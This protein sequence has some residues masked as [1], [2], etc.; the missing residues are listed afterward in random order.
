MAEA[1]PQPAAPQVDSIAAA[2]LAGSLATARGLDSIAAAQLL[3][4][5]ITARL[6]EL[7]VPVVVRDTIGVRFFHE[8]EYERW[9]VEQ[10]DSVDRAQ[11]ADS[12]GDPGAVAATPGEEARPGNGAGAADSVDIPVGLS[13]LILPTRNLV[14]VLDGQLPPGVSYEAAVAGAVNIYGTGGGGGVDTV[15]FEPPEPDTTDTV[16]P[17]DTTDTFDA[18]GCGGAP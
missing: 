15:R 4:S 13:G 17:S 8:Y 7:P 11:R 18:A 12:A 5:L 14:G 16:T 10:R 1:D 2:Q 6:A 3:D 9:R